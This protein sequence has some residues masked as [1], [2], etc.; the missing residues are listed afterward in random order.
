VKQ[1]QVEENKANPL[2]DDEPQLNDKDEEM[3]DP[4]TLQ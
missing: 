4:A 1:K 2:N 3:K